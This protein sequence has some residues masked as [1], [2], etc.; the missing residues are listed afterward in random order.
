MEFGYLFIY[1]EVSFVFVVFVSFT[2]VFS[3]ELGCAPKKD[4]Y[5]CIST[6]VCY[7]QKGGIELS[8]FFDA[9]PSQQMVIHLFGVVWV[10]LKMSIC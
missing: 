3:V 4:Q 1:Y 10:C 6:M 8:S 2:L 7:V 9:V 5:L